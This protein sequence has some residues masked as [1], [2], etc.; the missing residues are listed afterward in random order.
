ML[1]IINGK[2]YNTETATEVD[3]ISCPYFSSDF[4]WEETSLYVTPKGSWF[5][6]GR[7]HAM[8]RWARSTGGNG[9]APGSGIK[10]LTADEA[11]WFL[12]QENQDALIEE[13]FGEQLEDA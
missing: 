9:W 10:P 7:G 8:S 2:R 6:A 12:E 1:R 11:R 4:K 3:T 5:L 13:Y